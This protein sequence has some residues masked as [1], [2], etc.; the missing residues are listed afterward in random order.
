MA[1]CVDIIT[2]TFYL[3]LQ[4]FAFDGSIHGFE[5]SHNFP[6]LDAA[7]NRALP[8]PHALQEMAALVLEWLYRFDARA[9]DVAVANLEAELAIVERLLLHKAYALLEHSHL[10]EPVKVIEDDAPVALDNHDLP[11]LVG[12]GPANVHVSENI[13]RITE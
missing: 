11:R 3:H 7:A 12:I 10:L 6:S 13:A 2:F 5:N 1:I 8:R 9:D 4:S